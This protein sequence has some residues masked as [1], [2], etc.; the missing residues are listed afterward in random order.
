MGGV[1]AVRRCH[2]T[3]GFLPPPPLLVAVGVKGRGMPQTMASNLFAVDNNHHVAGKDMC[4]FFDN[5]HHV[6]GKDKF[7]AVRRCHNTGG[8]MAGG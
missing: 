3:G 4:V 2:N 8:S 1:F 7:L 5:N 6:A